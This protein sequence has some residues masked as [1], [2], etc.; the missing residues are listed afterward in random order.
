MKRRLLIKWLL[1]RLDR[2]ET[3]LVE[4]AQGGLDPADLQYKVIRIC[5]RLIALGYG[6]EDYQQEVNKNSG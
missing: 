2:C 5:A 3:K 1:W 4:Y 6:L